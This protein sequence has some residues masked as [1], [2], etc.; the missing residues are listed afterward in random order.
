MTDYISTPYF[1]QDVD[2]YAPWV[3]QHGLLYPYGECQ[4][5]C[6]Q[7]TKAAKRTDRRD[8]TLCNHP[9][10][11]IRNHHGRID[12]KNI[13]PPWIQVYGLRYPYGECQCGCG[14][15]TGIS[16]RSEDEFGTKRGCH[17]R[18]LP[19]HGRRHP[20]PCESPNPSGLCMCGCGRPSP[21]A[22]ASS[23]RSGAVKGQPMRYVHG[24]TPPKP[25]RGQTFWARVSRPD[26]CVC[27]EW[28]GGKKPDGYGSAGYEGKSDL[29]HR[30]AW[31]LTKGP[32][33]KGMYICHSCDNPACCNPAHLFLGTQ[34]DNMKDM[35]VKGR[36][37]R[38][39]KT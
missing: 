33:P 23:K 26:P 32:I 1:P 35:I 16:H 9:V 14:K 3:T 24:H 19:G 22:K 5:G 13:L 7:K 17:A 28:Q 21:I 4:C 20:V 2:N 10:R 34:S 8:G 6:G 29:A 15:K 38:Q 31:K 12:T 39:R 18:F 11:F 30:V 37:Y 27:W 36:H 25:P